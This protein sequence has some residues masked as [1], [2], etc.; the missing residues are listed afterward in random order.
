MIKEKCNTFKVLKEM[1]GSFL[2]RKTR[3]TNI[4]AQLLV[5]IGDVGASEVKVEG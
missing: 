1:Y 4:L 3:N 2:V 5:T